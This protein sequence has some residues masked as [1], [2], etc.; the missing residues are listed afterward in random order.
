MRLPL[1]LIGIICVSALCLGAP[2]GVALSWDPDHPNT[3]CATIWLYYLMVRCDYRLD[4][5]AALPAS[6]EI[7]PSFEEE[8]CARQTAVRDYREQK[9]KDR[10]FHDDYWETLSKVESKGFIKPY[11]WVYLHRKNWADNDRPNNLG[12]FE[13]WRQS[14][15]RSH[16]AETFGS[17]SVQK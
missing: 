11:V 9:V 7:V 15:L 5:K 10:H 4:H 6:G 2:P 1:T 8:V 3:K 12:A 13:A 16:R 14:A 17:L